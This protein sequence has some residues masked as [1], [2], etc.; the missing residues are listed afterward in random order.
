MSLSKVINLIDNVTA[1]ANNNDRQTTR[2][3]FSS[4]NAEYDRYAPITSSPIEQAN[5]ALRDRNIK[6]ADAEEDEIQD[7]ITTLRKTETQRFAF[8]SIVSSFLFD[9]AG[10]DAGTVKSVGQKLKSSEEALDREKSDTEKLINGINI[11]PRPIL[12]NVDC[13]DSVVPFG[14]IIP[15]EFTVSNPSSEQLNTATADISVGGET[16]CSELEVGTIGPDETVTIQ[17]KIASPKAGEQPIEVITNSPELNVGRSSQDHVDIRSKAPYALFATNNLETLKNIIENAESIMSEQK[18]SITSEIRIAIEA[19]NRA[20]QNAKK[21]SRNSATREKSRAKE[22]N[23]LFTSAQEALAQARREYAITVETNDIP[24]KVDTTIRNY[25]SLADQNLSEGRIAGLAESGENGRANKSTE[26]EPVCKSSTDQAEGL[27]IQYNHIV[28]N[29]EGII[30]ISIYLTMIHGED[31]VTV[32]DTFGSKW[33]VV[34]KG[35]GA[36]IIE[37]DKIQF[38]NIEDSDN[39][40]QI[41]KRQYQIAPSSNIDT[42]ELPI[43]FRMGPTEVKFRDNSNHEHVVGRSEWAVVTAESRD[44]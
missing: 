39:P 21:S 24:S 32:T 43:H 3:A 38:E 19:T 10:F 5:E 8:A 6:L 26:T 16:A 25:F 14:R 15:V 41:I 31:K 4:L 13:R 11:P 1:A 22:I 7:A 36:K 29:K 9:P 35:D 37:D 30:T 34:N 2:E 42:E 44:E 33:N 20:Y 18:T 23:S 12:I 27:R 28:S 40:T 17:R